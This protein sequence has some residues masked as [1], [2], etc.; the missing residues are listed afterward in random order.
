MR[1]AIFACNWL[2]GSNAK[3]KKLTR[4]RSTMTMRI[5]NKQISMKKKIG[6][7]EFKTKCFSVTEHTF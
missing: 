4:I 5:D 6:L 2:S 1:C 3:Y 7:A